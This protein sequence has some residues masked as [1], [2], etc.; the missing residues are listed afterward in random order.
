VGAPVCV[1]PLTLGCY[2]AGGGL[3]AADDEQSAGSS[4]PQIRFRQT[5]VDEDQLR[6]VPA[7]LRDSS[8]E[9]RHKDERAAGCWA[10]GLL[11]SFACAMWAGDFL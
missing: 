2:R 1:A 6:N 10:V 11:A 5:N 3:G 8:S 7:V 9:G 4:E